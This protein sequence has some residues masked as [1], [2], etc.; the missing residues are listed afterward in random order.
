MYDSP[1][2]GLRSS[3]KPMAVTWSH[4]RTSSRERTLA[5]GIP[6]T[7]KVDSQSDAG[8]KTSASS[9]F[10]VSASRLRTRSP[11]DANRGSASNSGRPSTSHSL[12]Q[13]R[14]FPA[15]ARTM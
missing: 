13:R 6:S 4:N 7:S 3:N 2:L 10:T 12:T 14:S 9:S 8:R 1:K 15:P 11:L 5:D